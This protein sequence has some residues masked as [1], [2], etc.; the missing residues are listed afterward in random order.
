MQI[1]AVRVQKQVK[2]DMLYMADRPGPVR[3]WLRRLER[4]TAARLGR[5]RAIKV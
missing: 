3:R 5:N 1:A 2:W 4:G